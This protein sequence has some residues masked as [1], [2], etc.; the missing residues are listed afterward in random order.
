[1]TPDQRSAFLPARWGI[2]GFLLG[3]LF[4][5][6]ATLLELRLSQTPFTLVNLFL[7][8]V[9]EP[10]LLIVDTAPLVLGVLAAVL[11]QREQ[12]L[13]TLTA[14][15]ETIVEE[16]TGQLRLRGIIVEAA[17][18]SILVTDNQEKILWV[19]AAY[20]RVTGYPLE[21]LAG[22]SFREF[23]S[24][25]HDDAFQ[26]NIRRTVMSGHIW[27]GEVVD[28]RKD[29]SLYTSERSI[30]PVLGDDNQLT[31][32]V[33]IFQDVT[34]RQQSRLEVEKQ[35]QYFETLFTTSPVAIVMV[36]SDS[37]IHTCNPAFEQL[38]GYDQRDIAGKNIDELIVPPSE[39]DRAHHISAETLGGTVVH[40]LSQRMRSDGTAVDVEILSAPVIVN[41]EHVGAFA[42]YHDIS[43]LVRARQKAEAAAQAKADF[44]ANMSHELRTPLNGVIGMTALLRDTPLNDE[45]HTFVETLRS[46]GDSLLAVI[47]DILDFSKIEAGK[48][49]LEQRPFHLHDCIESA[50]DLLATKAAEKG[51]ELAYL[52]HANTPSRIIGDITRLRQ[53]LL[54]LLGNAVKF[55][56]AGEVVVNVSGEPVGDDVYDLHFVIRD[57]GI[58]IPRDR[59]GRLFQAFSQVDSSTTRKYGG[60]GLGL[61]IS[62]SLVQLMG[63]SIWVESE[64]GK[65][66]AFH[67]TVRCETAQDASDAP[68]LKA[69]IQPELQGRSVLIV[70]D[71]ATNRL[72]LSRQVA[73]WG[74][75]PH[76]FASP[77]EAL[78]DVVK[79]TQHD[80]AIVDMQMPEMDGL[81]L[82]REIR[83]LPNGA[84]LPLI[85]LTSLGRR[86]D[87]L[88]EIG[89]SAQLNKPIRAAHMFEAL[90]SALSDRPR[91]VRHK[92]TTP[93]FNAAFGH[94]HPLRILIAED[95][96][97]NKK[98]AVA[99]LQ[100]IG[101]L[102]DVVGN[103]IEA[104]DALRG[105]PY[106]VLLLDMEMP[107]MGGEET[108]GHIAKEWPPERRPRV[109]AMTAHAFEGDREKYLASGMD[110]YVS[111]PIRPEELMRALAAS[112][113]L[114]G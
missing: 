105:Q 7:T 18:N 85:M 35:R 28:R 72:I 65:G 50:L 9:H 101:Y 97:V 63:G 30:T 62:R 64:L 60:T 103:G 106:D 48:L 88:N 99:I 75:E 32:V 104:L 93:K 69:G 52:V 70:D 46:S 92:A 94:Q 114:S 3:A 5:I 68:V 71:N 108:A 13:R 61:S 54:N 42:L 8:N 49:S 21:E 96:L 66:S 19:N 12:R 37:A 80:A 44:L 55:T 112:H 34:E 15:L 11:G 67:F 2:I 53:V 14:Q 90:A 1:M 73:G 59:L 84:S 76:A 40:A 83:K 43:E 100:R 102:P 38:F 78:A 26:E 79:G 41:G 74:L 47:N 86:P 107:E 6:L 16:R 4:P 89:F 36:S 81:T 45:Q 20:S 111:K 27:T 77:V 24:R 31:H 82:A 39:R 51:L 113:P 98:V 23:V 87:E 58:G 109:I 57:T 110:D 95:N 29:G 56:D 25:E 22:H 91:I 17:A 10:L 33:T